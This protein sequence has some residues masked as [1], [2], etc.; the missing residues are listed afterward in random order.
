MTVN[1]Y[2]TGI[3][4]FIELLHEASHSHKN[5]RAAHNETEA[6]RSPRIEDMYMRTNQKSGPVRLN[7][8]ITIRNIR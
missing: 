3:D 5:N 1:N 8:R 6:E 2:Q 7:R 4:S